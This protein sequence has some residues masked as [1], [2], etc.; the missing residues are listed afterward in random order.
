MDAEEP[1]PQVPE[2]EDD[3]DYEPSDEESDDDYDDGE[4]V[5]EDLSHL[6]PANI[7]S[8]PQ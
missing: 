2:P 1:L 7:I 8:L 3:S 5:P 4:V 6:D